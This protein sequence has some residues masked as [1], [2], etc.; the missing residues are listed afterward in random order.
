[1][2]TTPDSSAPPIASPRART[3]SRPTTDYLAARSTPASLATTA[4]ERI[5]TAPTTVAYRYR[6]CWPLRRSEP[7]QTVPSSVCLITVDQQRRRLLFDARSGLD[8]SFL[9]DLHAINVAPRRLGQLAG[10]PPGHAGTALDFAGGD[11]N[12]ARARLCVHHE[13]ESGVV[14]PLSSRGRSRHHRGRRLAL[15]APRPGL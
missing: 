5:D 14:S 13:G 11:R 9:P 2:S 3:S 10:V 7:A 4:V 12:R 15:P 6:P 8:L 1:M